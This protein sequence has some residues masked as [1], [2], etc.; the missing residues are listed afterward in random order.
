MLAHLK[1]SILLVWQLLLPVSDS[2]LLWPSNEESLFPDTSLPLG[3]TFFDSIELSENQESLFEDLDGSILLPLSDTDGVTRRPFS[4]EDSLDK[5]I[6]LADCSSENLSTMDISMVK[7]IA[8]SGSC[9]NTAAELQSDSED[10][11]QE[12]VKLLGDDSAT[13]DKLTETMRNK[14]AHTRCVFYTLSLLPWGVCSSGW[15]PDEIPLG[16]SISI[17]TRGVFILYTLEYYKLGKL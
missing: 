1:L 8:E 9:K 14:A 2:N 7:R 11:F 12:R 3:Q 6:E 4:K 13:W 15:L 16:E 10:A 17:P 5:A